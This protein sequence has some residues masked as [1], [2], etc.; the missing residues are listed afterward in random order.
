[1]LNHIFYFQKFKRVNPDI[2]LIGFFYLCI[3]KQSH[4]YD[5]WVPTFGNFVVN[6]C[7]VHN[8]IEQDA[9]VVL[10]LYREDYYNPMKTPT[11]IADVIIAKHRNGPIGTIHISFDSNVAS[12]GNLII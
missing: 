3:I 9:D 4:V 5:I 8:S 2:F 1:M 6:D 7:V 10:M 11:S 12:F